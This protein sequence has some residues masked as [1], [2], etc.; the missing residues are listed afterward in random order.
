MNS[1]YNFASNCLIPGNIL[2]K[3][4]IPDVQYSPVKS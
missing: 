1:D 3:D 2:L 4:M